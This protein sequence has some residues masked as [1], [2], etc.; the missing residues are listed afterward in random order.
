MNMISRKSE[1]VNDIQMK[2]KTS[3]EEIIQTIQ[4]YKANTKYYLY[5]KF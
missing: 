2:I 5:R 4:M 3:K 1:K